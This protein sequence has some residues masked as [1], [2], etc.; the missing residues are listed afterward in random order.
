MDRATVINQS[1]AAFICGLLGLMPLIGVPFGMAALGLFFVTRHCRAD[2]NP[3]Q[4]YLD[5]G[6]R[7]ALLGFALTLFAFTIL[8]LAIINAQLS[9]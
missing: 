7:L 8:S 2:W 3:A 1:I 9:N 5:W 6:V 4:H